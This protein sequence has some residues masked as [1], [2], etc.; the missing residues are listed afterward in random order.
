MPEV[1]CETEMWYGEHSFPTFLERVSVNA[2]ADPERRFQHPLSQIC[3]EI[4]RYDSF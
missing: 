4:S 2:M 3:D 1:L